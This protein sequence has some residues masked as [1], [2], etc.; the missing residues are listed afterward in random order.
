MDKPSKPSKPRKPSEPKPP[1][2]KLPRF[3]FIDLDMRNDGDNISI[4]DLLEKI[5]EGIGLEDICIQV[6]D[7]E[8]YY[9]CACNA[10]YSTDLRLR[11]ASISD[12]PAYEHE[13]RKYKRNHKKWLRKVEAYKE[14][15]A[16]YEKLN[17]KCL[18][19]MKKWRAYSKEEQI[20]KLEEQLTKLKGK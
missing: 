6:V 1:K 20:K 3:H 18:A 8:C 11:Y 13:M 15:L 12:N 10:S 16:N 17:K 4:K 5:P 14:K 2:E 19:D 7:N 9:E